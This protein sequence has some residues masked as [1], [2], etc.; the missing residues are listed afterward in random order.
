VLH[1]PGIAG[2]GAGRPR[3]AAPF[4]RCDRVILY[5]HDLRQLSPRSAAVPGAPSPREGESSAYGQN[6]CRRISLGR[7]AKKGA[8]SGDLR[9][10]LRLSQLRRGVE[11]DGR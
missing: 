1:K 9:G 4:P 10:W 11:S 8:L 6:Y 2:R 5:L 7:S 3:V